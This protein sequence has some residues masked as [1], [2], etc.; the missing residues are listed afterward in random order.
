MSLSRFNEPPVDPADTERS[1]GEF[2]RWWNSGGADALDRHFAEQ[3]DSSP[4]APAC[5]TT[6]DKTTADE[7]AMVTLD[8]LVKAIHPDLEWKV[9][10]GV[11]CSPHLLTV[12][13]AHDPELRAEARRWFD[14]APVADEAWS[15]GDL[16]PATP[17]VPVE[18]G[19]QVYR[20]EEC[21]VSIRTGMSLVHVTVYHPSM[22]MSSTPSKKTAYLLL[23]ALLGEEATELW[24]GSVDGVPDP[25]P[26]SVP[27]YLLRDEVERFARSFTPENGERHWQILAARQPSEPAVVSVVPPLD[28]ITAPLS[29][30]HVVATVEYSDQIEQGLPGPDAREKLRDLEDL[31]LGRF[32]DH[33]RLVAVE[34]GAGLRRFHLYRDPTAA[35]RTPLDRWL[36]TWTGGPTELQSHHDPAWSKVQ[37]FRR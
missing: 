29:T 35:T 36:A 3:S 26:G 8:G 1:V 33:E 37:Q 27:F 23:D 13:A 4:P 24:I 15:F 2:W 22:A 12:T 28:S 20:I 18:I 34:T 30:E 7:P 6:A 25:D 31:L 21:L 32:A 5:K 9:R 19:G 10:P 17:D 14:A 16:L 11:E